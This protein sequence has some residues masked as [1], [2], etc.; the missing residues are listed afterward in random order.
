[1]RSRGNLTQSVLNSVGFIHCH[2]DNGK[3]YK[4]FSF[5][6][7]IALA[8]IADVSTRPT[9]EFAIYVVT[10]S[11][12]FA[13]TIK[14][15][16]GLKKKLNTMKLFIKNYETIMEEKFKLTDNLQTQIKGL[17]KFMKENGFSNMIDLYQK[18]E[19]DQKW[20]RLALNRNETEVEP[21][22]CD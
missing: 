13:L 3:T 19:T 17:L 22:K 18:D 1:M 14:D 5:S 9:P 16:I 11:G 20:Q 8:Q 12:T 7:F 21:K 6:D 15:K 10:S 4:V 2:L